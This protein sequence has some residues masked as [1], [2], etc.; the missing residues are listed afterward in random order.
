[1]KGFKLS[2]RAKSAGLELNVPETSGRVS[3][4]DST[5]HPTIET[6]VLGLI[7]LWPD[8]TLES[9]SNIP[10]EV[11]VVAIHGLGG[12]PYKSWREGEKLWLKDFLPQDVPT[13]R[14][15]T[16][17]YNAS[18]AFT[19]TNSTIRD[20]AISLLEE[21]RTFRRRNKEQNRKFIFVCHSL[22][23]IVLKQ[24]CRPHDLCDNSNFLPKALIIAHE[25]ESRYAEIEKSVAG[26][27]FLGT[28]HRGAEVAYWSKFLT[29]IAN[30]FTAGKT[31]GDLLRSLAPKS[32]ELGTICSQ[33]VERAVK[34]QIF[35]L[36]ERHDFPGLGSLIVDEH[37]AILH[38]NNETAIPMETDHR[39]ICNRGEDPSS[40][41]IWK[42][43]FFGFDDKDPTRKTSDSFIRSVLSQILND[44]RC[45]T[46]I[47]YIDKY[48]Y[49]D[50]KRIRISEEKIWDS[51]NF[52]INEEGLWECLYIIMTRSRGI[53]FLLVIDALDE[54]LRH[55]SSPP[56]IVDRLRH[57]A[58]SNMDCH[59]KLLLS[60]RQGPPFEFQQSM[61]P[62][63]IDIDNIH[64]RENV[65]RFIRTKVRSSL[66]ASRRSPGIATAIEEKIIKISQ[67][68]FLYA[69]LAWEQ[70][71][72]DVTHWT[73]DQINISLDR[74][75]SASGDL[76]N[77]YCRLLGNISAR[78]QHN[79]K[80]AF[81]VLRYC[82]ERL[83]S[84]QL[85]TLS[86]LDGISLVDHHRDL[87]ELKAQAEDFEAY[88][89]EA[90]EYII[91]IEGQAVEFAH[92]SAKDV[93]STDLDILTPANRQILSQYA[94]SNSH[95][96]DIMFRLCLKTMHMERRSEAS[97]SKEYHYMAE[98][99]RRLLGGFK[100]T[101]PSQDEIGL[102]NASWVSSVEKISRTTCLK[103]A[104]RNWFQHYADVSPYDINHD[105]ATAFLN[106][107]TGCYCYL[108]WYELPTFDNKAKM[109][110]L[111][112]YSSAHLKVSSSMETSL[113]RAI[114]L[115]DFP[116]LVKAML[117][118]GVDANYIA[119]KITPLSWAIMCQRPYAFQ[120]LLEHRDIQVNRGVH[121]EYFPI[122]HAAQCLEDTFYLKKLLECRNID[123]NVMCTTGT[124]LHEALSWRNVL[125]A[126][127]ILSHPL[128]D[129]WCKDKNGDT[130]YSMA[131]KHE[132][133]ELLLLR[134]FDMHEGP[135]A[136]L[137][138]Q[139]SGSSEFLWAGVHGWTDME[140]KILREDHEQVFVVSDDSGLNAL[141]HYA[142]FGRKEKLNWILDRLPTYGLPLRCA[143]DRYDLLH[144][145]AS[146]DWEDV[147]HLLQRRYGLQ[148][149]RSDHQ[150]RNLLHWAMDHSWDL[151][152]FNLEQYDISHL[153]SLDRDR[154]TP[155]HIAVS[156][157]NMDA[158]DLLVASGASTTLKDKNGMSPAHLAA[159]VGW[160]GG[161]EY[162]VETPSAGI[163]VTRDGATLLHQVATWFEGKLVH[164]IIV[165]KKGAV[166][167]TDHRRRT[168]LHYASI[169]NNKS[170]M[171][172]LL[173]AGG[174]IDATDENGMTPLHEAIRCL[175]GDTARFLL[176]RGANYRT[177]DGFKQ[178]CLH[179]SVRYQHSYLIKKFIRLGLAADTYDTFGM[180]PLHRACS[181]GNQKHVE[182][183]LR[184]GASFTVMN[185]YRRCPL[186]MAAE[187]ENLDAVK[188]FISWLD[189][190]HLKHRKR[191]S[192][193]DRA[194]LRAYESECEESGRILRKAGGNVDKSH[195]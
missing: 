179:L 12:H 11:D 62:A 174:P 188:A 193:L 35:S 93:F 78:Y 13:A 91:K 190:L 103:Y 63:I 119:G 88:L 54:V 189:T 6:P 181:T 9:S 1:M 16:F 138:R 109:A 121:L 134:M 89:V 101:I 159:H 72:N 115:G 141:T 122:H 68:N 92:V 20:F 44:Q 169:N 14:V 61:D 56:T 161:V 47:K 76:I 125:A 87:Q 57:L 30:V 69:T 27:I 81:T 158:L 184:E 24:I 110:F 192:I 116:H 25:R 156:N 114:T 90:C 183:L 153:D 33:F 191:Q 146:Q 140:E 15:L 107:L 71:S 194:L 173:D 178:S 26:V 36:Y 70:F 53:M 17:G 80:I 195:V 167:D 21:L 166:N 94:V 186:D 74:L 142:Y 151:D 157:R 128:V 111:P 85:A 75:D 64:T 42:P 4:G 154:M 100:S 55:N 171:K 10:T 124:A 49:I 150:G 162:F 106:S 143:S 132:M 65:D 148:S 135:E 98:A 97:W 164:K 155:V 86:V 129:I 8:P 176:Q 83:S 3:S 5:G 152:R 51:T 23:G 96:H 117:R 22:G 139:I 165:S 32:T 102:V 67:G 50:P 137:V 175:A 37:S 19:Q 163:G 18:I 39:G 60:H 182:L 2:S 112:R 41:V 95:G 31:R 45:A 113:F 127:M 43:I 59:M 40:P 52:S 108:L 133:W 177:L 130:P 34:L 149:L 46:V 168:P 160:R 118:Q 99:A 104:I 145:C 136:P 172:V 29:K 144:L 7:Q 38:L 48:V 131:F 126:N 84:T 82:K 187:R 185:R 105:L 66:Q 170:A 147:V 123:V 58:Q 77:F 79:A 120:A 28:P 73:K 180:N